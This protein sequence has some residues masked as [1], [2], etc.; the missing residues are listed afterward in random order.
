[1]YMRR[2]CFFVVIL[3]LCFFPGLKARALADSAA[4]ACLMNAVTGEILFEKNADEP[5]PMA[6]TTKIMTLITALELSDP[7]EIIIV[8]HEATLE[9]GSS[10]YIEE[11]SQITMRE[12]FYGLMLNSG[13][14]AAVAI[15]CHI[16]GSEA[17]FANEMNRKAREI[18]VKNTNFMNANGL[19]EDGHY[20]TARDL[21]I[22]TRYAM[23]DPLFREIVATRVHPTSFVRAGGET[24][25]FDYINHNK[26]L[27]SLEGCIGVKTGYTSLDG[28]C[29]VSAAERNGAMFIAVTLNCPNDW[30]EHRE[31]MEYAFSNTR[32]VNVV[33][34]GDCIKYAVS[35]GDRCKLVAETDFNVP[36]TGDAGRDFE[37][38][39]KLPLFIYMPLNAN[40][41]IGEIEIYDRGNFI[42]KVNVV[43]ESDFVP[44]KVAAVRTSFWYLLISIL[45]SILG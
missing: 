16:S 31:L 30:E 12:L 19:D 34:A 1:M 11:G 22:I 5:L 42:G 27:G 40:E 20:T 43:A 14:D 4:S 28:R 15:A 45:R 35:N 44:D 10:A 29:L 13:N 37:L 6:S 2:P 7:E 33:K 3:M 41:K 36:V 39:T 23:N 26:L 32:I 17:E 25:S 38:R 18:G 8:P 9:E 21:A 24:K